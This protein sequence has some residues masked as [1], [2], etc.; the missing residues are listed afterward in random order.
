M[1]IGKRHS[2][3]QFGAVFIVVA[4]LAANMQFAQTG[5][6]QSGFAK[7]RRGGQTQRATPHRTQLD[8]RWQ[9]PARLVS[10]HASN[11]QPAPYGKGRYVGGFRCYAGTLA[12]DDGTDAKRRAG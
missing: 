12:E 8:L 6:S 10:L 11:Q 5:H 7:L 3:F 9:A 2:I 1:M 4:A